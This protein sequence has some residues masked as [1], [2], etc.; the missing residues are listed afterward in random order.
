MKRSKSL[1]GT[2]SVLPKKKQLVINKKKL[3][4]TRSVSRDPM[5][6]VHALVEHLMSNSHAK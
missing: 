2:R 4:I 6:D 5:F 1:K 3:Q